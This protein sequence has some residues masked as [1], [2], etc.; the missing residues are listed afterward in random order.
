LEEK[1]SST[2]LNRFSVRLCFTAFAALLALTPL[3]AA[4]VP[5]AQGTASTP[6]GGTIV[7]PESS[8]EHPNDVGIR[9]HTNI[10]IMVPLGG[11]PKMQIKAKNS[12]STRGVKCQVKPQ[13]KPKKEGD[14]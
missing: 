9:A 2:L 8:V 7:I 13:A 12:P 3:A 5:P 1:R 10:G 11:M 4:Q 6:I 14:S